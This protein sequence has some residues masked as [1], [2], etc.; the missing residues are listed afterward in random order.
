MKKIVQKENIGNNVRLL[1]AID[2]EQLL[3]SGLLSI[4]D[5][6][7]SA[8]KSETFGLTGIEAM[9]HK[10]TPV[11]FRTQGLSEVVDGAALLCKSNDTEGF[12]KGILTLF[13]D[14]ELRLEMGNKGRKIAN[15]YN[16]ESVVKKQIK[17]YEDVIGKYKPS[18]GSVKNL[19]RVLHIDKR[20]SK[21]KKILSRL[22]N[23]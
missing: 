2:H 22:R 20:L 5:I 19:N 23:I 16:S 8:S 7:V 15:F 17:I 11:L 21:Y 1:G 10:L 6:F 9:A 18:R 12:K 14:N 4:C 13:K 3:S